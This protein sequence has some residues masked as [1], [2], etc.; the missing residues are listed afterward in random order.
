MKE[1]FLKLGLTE[2]TFMLNVKNSTTMETV[3]KFDRYH[4]ILRA[5]RDVTFSK[6]I[7][8]KLVGGQR[9]LERLVAE[10]KI[11]APKSTDKQNGRWLCNAEDVLRYTVDP[12]GTY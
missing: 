12:T 10:G 9:R 7:S 8:Q 3:Q 11:R 5:A 6:N 4:T 1:K 2:I